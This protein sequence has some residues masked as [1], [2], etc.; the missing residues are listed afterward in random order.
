MPRK[1]RD[2]LERT[3]ENALAPGVF[4]GYRDRWDFVEGVEAV[5]AKVAALMEMGEAEARRAVAL[6][7][8]FIAGCYEKSEE[9]DDS[10]GSFGQLVGDLFCDWIRARQAAG[11]DP[12]D[13][14]RMLLSWME[15]DNYGYCHRLEKEA[16]KVID[17]AGLVAFE[18]AVRER[19]S[20]EG[21][22]VY[23]QRRKV[24]IL[25]VIHEAR[26]NV[27]AYAA[28]CEAEG[29]LAP[30]DCEALAKMCLERRRPGDALAWVER[31]LELEK[32][33]RFPNRPSWGLPRLEREILKKLGR[34]GEALAS[35]WEH[36]QRAPSV[37]SYQDLMK[38]VAKGERAEWHAKALAALDEADL[39]QRIELLLKTR[40]W[41]RLAEAIDAASREDLVEVSHYTIEP[42]AKRLEKSHP[43]LAAKLYVAMA[44]R[45]LE[46]KKS[47]YYEAALGNLEKARKLLLREG[48]ASVW[49]ALAAEIRSEH[50]RKTGFMPGFERVEE[51]RSLREPSFAE[52]ARRRWR[53]GSGFGR[54]RS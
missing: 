6:L 22:E 27:G 35:A 39:S 50:R 23:A 31:G 18:R 34:S 4:V 8:T 19:P 13:T 53:Q 47:K 43:L 41:T 52:R 29:G 42:A 30:A 3:I 40:E 26:R 37:F 11:A 14:A 24:E 7:E 20:E 46:A 48:Q 51:G 32:A 5:R 2:E 28:L 45:I 10:G 12:A 33:G 9:I 44:L 49:E 17:R 36:Y 1:R 21:R 16:V 15:N 25:K 54:R 38:F